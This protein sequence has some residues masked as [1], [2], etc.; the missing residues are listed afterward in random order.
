MA[1]QSAPHWVSRRQGFTFTNH[2]SYQLRSQTGQQGTVRLDLDTATNK[3]A[4]EW[5]LIAALAMTANSEVAIGKVTLPTE[6]KEGKRYAC[7]LTCSALSFSALHNC[8]HQGIEDLLS[9]RV[10]QAVYH[11]EHQS[12]TLDAKKPVGHPVV[13]FLRI[14]ELHRTP[15]HTVGSS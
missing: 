5:T 7:P 8:C 11:Q 2:G 1:W 9:C 12:V 4:E 3:K 6:C 14:S 15:V 10:G 13:I